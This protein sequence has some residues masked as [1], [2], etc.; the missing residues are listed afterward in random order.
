MPTPSQIRV[1]RLKGEAAIARANKRQLSTK[2]APES[3]LRL[4]AADW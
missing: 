2:R 3:L 4:P 1:R